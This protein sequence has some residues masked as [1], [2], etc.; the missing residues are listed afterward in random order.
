MQ[1]G[2]GRVMFHRE[3]TAWHSDKHTPCD[4]QHICDEAALVLQT[5]NML[6]HGVG[7]G[8]VE[9]FI[10]EGQRLVRYDLSVRH[11]RKSFTKFFSSANP[12]CSNAIR[13]RVAPF[14]YIGSVTDYIGDPNV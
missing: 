7:G 5:P 14:Q 9:G 8:N 4:A 2:N 10:R 11:P 3:K 1:K 13:V 6:Q 12:S